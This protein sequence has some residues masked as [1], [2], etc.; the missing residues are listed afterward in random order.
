[1]SFKLL[2]SVRTAFNYIV[3]I[4]S[5]KDDVP[6]DI[7]ELIKIIFSPD[8]E[9]SQPPVT[10]VFLILFFRLNSFHLRKNKAYPVQ[11]NK[12][13]VTPKLGT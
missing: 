1:M 7:N 11:R 13:L 10:D 6:N 4:R 2:N 8:S 3:I 5:I 12:P 9:L